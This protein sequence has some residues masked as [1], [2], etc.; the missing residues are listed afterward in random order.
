MSRAEVAVIIARKLAR[1]ERV[2]GMLAKRECVDRATTRESADMTAEEKARLD[3]IGNAMRK[4]L[5]L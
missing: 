2:A 5:A 1:A 4:I 3:R